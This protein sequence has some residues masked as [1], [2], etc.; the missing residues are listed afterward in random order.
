MKWSVGDNLHAGVSGVC[1]TAFCNFYQVS[2]SHVDNLVRECKRGTFNSSKK[3]SDRSVVDSAI[4]PHLRKL[5]AGYGI[6]LTRTQVA[7]AKLPNS[8]SVLSAYGWMAE[9]F[10]LIGD[11]APNCDG[12]I[13]LEPT[14]LQDMTN[15]GLS[16]VNVDTFSSIWVNC[17]W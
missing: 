2:S 8:P 9:H 15:A 12:E 10:S 1:K 3:L 17:R 16:S 6:T 13:H 14:H 5:A 4:L 11:M 7:A